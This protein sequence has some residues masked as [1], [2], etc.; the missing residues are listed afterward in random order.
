[1]QPDPEASRHG[2]NKQQTLGECGSREEDGRE[3]SKLKAQVSFQS[4]GFNLH[5]GGGI[6]TFPPELGV[7]FE[8]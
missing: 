8:L 2:G 3:S 5:Q 6:G 7:N 4:P 1:M